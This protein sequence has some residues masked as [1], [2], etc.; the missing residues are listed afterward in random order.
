[1]ISDLPPASDPGLD[2]L[3]RF[4]KALHDADWEAPDGVIRF[5]SDLPLAELGGAT[6]LHNARVFLRALA[7]EG[8]AAATTAGNL[9]RVFVGRRLEQLTLSAAHRE[10]TRRVCKVINEMDGWPLH[11]ARVVAE[12]GRLVARRD[13]RFVLTKL[14][15]DLLPDERAGA[16]FRHLFIMFFRKLDLRYVARFRDV[17]EIQQTMAITLGGSPTWRTIGAR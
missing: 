6:F 14:G 11:E 2:A 8:G 15:R 13:R 17:P 4:L 1:M 12:L 5:S 16:L 9:N 7:E 10:S 3:N